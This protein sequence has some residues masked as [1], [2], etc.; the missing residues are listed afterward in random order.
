MTAG[1]R[2]LPAFFRDVPGDRETTIRWL[3]A[4]QHRSQQITD[5]SFGSR[6]PHCPGGANPN[7][8]RAVPLP[9]EGREPVT[10]RFPASFPLGIPPPLTW[11]ITG[12]AQGLT[13]PELPASEQMANGP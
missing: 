1:L 7:Q 5:P 6:T 13:A 3:F 8:L 12:N 10:A 2:Q 11:P 9:L 4:E